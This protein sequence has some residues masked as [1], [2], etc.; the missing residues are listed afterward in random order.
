MTTIQWYLAAKPVSCSLSNIPLDKLKLQYLIEPLQPCNFLL[1]DAYLRERK[2]GGW[3]KDFTGS[4]PL[5]LHLQQI[6]F[7]LLGINR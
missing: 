1:G 7:Q 2:D 5:P 6:Y 3:R 4:E